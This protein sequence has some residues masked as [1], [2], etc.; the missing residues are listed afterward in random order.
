[1]P[2]ERPRL[3]IIHTTSDLLMEITGWIL[4]V[5]VWFIVLK[6]YNS[7]P[8]IIP[9]HYSANGNADGH[10]PKVSILLLPAIS[11][12][13]YIGMTILNKYPHIFNYPAVITRENAL[14]QY[15]MATRMIRV[16]KLAIV[17]LFGV[18]ALVTLRNVKTGQ[19]D[20]GAAFLPA[21][22]LLIFVPVA[23]FTIKSLK[24]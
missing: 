4:L 1:M 2:E 10:G 14:K 21:S 7:L 8:D 24:K 20:L 22:M 19:E 12:I 15:T 13:A 23:Y 16:L 6:A 9:T 11:T 3:K 18:I 5:M 17:V